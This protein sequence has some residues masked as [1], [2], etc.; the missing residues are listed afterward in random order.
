M[1][2]EHFVDN[3]LLFHILKLMNKE[4]LFMKDYIFLEWS[5]FN[6]YRLMNGFITASK[7]RFL[8]K[9]FSSNYNLYD[10]SIFTCVL[11]L[12]DTN[13][14]YND[15]KNKMLYIGYLER[16]Y[17]ETIDPRYIKKVP[18]YVN[19]INS[20]KISYD[21][22]IELTASLARI[23]LNPAPFVIIYCNDDWICFKDFRFKEDMELFNQ[24]IFQQFPIMRKKINEIFL[25]MQHCTDIKETVSYFDELEKIHSVLSKLMFIEGIKIPQDLNNF[26]RDFDNMRDPW[27]REYLFN[28]IK[29]KNYSLDNQLEIDLNTKVSLKKFKYMSFDA[30]SDCDV[31][32]M[33]SLMYAFCYGHQPAIDLRASLIF[34][35]EYLENIVNKIEYISYLCLESEEKLNNIDL[36]CD[37]KV[38]QWWFYDPRYANSLS[39]DEVNVV[40]LAL[41]DVCK[42]FDGDVAAIISNYND[43]QALKYKLQAIFAIKDYMLLQ[44]SEFKYYRHIHDYESPLNLKYLIY[45]FSIGYLPGKN[46]NVYDNSVLFRPLTDLDGIF[47]YN[48]YKNKMLYIGCAEWEVDE[49]INPPNVEEF[50]YYV[51]EENSCKISHENFTELVYKMSKLKNN[52]APFALIYR[53]NSDW[54]RCKGFSFKEEFEPFLENSDKVMI[55][56]KIDSL[57]SKI[58]EIKEIKDRGEVLLDKKDTEKNRI[59]FLIGGVLSLLIKCLVFS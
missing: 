23:K 37:L 34:D 25:H 14:V 36:I 21:N 40:I 53:D 1:H 16:A 54:V 44:W 22:F 46:Y 15:H 20:C 8:I 33:R 38:D 2:S 39:R 55:S 6:D 27:L 3:L 24:N 42:N 43:L 17:N 13:F 48:D 59:I 9:F 29:A 52:P 5:E 19:E 58:K 12:Y 49:T 56:V 7:L 57:D 30:L 35:R 50:P 11:N 45:F 28:Q 31:L 10:T 47:V 18:Y 4:Q 41:Q 51:T 26:F 32:L